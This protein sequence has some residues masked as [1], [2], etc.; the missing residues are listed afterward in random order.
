MLLEIMRYNIK[1]TAMLRLLKLP[2]L[3]L[4][5]YPTVKYEEYYCWQDECHH[6]RIQH[7]IHSVKQLAAWGF[8]VRA[9]TV[10]EHTLDEQRW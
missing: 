7:K 10:N 2:V 1:S 9:I 5:E 6:R 8:S 3:K 4:T